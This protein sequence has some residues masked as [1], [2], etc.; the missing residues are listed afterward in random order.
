[1]NVWLIAPLL[2]SADAAPGFVLVEAVLER[3]QQQP[4]FLLRAYGCPEPNRDRACRTPESAW[5]RGLYRT[6]IFLPTTLSV[7]IVGFS[8]NLIV[9][10]LA[11]LRVLGK[12]GMVQIEAMTLADRILVMNHGR[13]E[14]VGKPLEL[15]YAL[16]TCLSSD[17]SASRR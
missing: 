7:V 14:Q 9:S 4:H 13:I 15:Y 16:A 12:R 6:I 10:R 11:A 2:P 1:M 17:S 5:P 3:G 8:W